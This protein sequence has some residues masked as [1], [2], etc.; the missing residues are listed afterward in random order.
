MDCP[1]RWERIGDC[2]QEALRELIFRESKKHDLRSVAPTWHDL[3]RHYF[4]EELAFRPAV[5]S[6]ARH[7]AKHGVAPQGLIPDSRYY[8]CFRI[9]CAL[10]FIGMIFPPQASVCPFS[11]L[12][13]SWSDNQVIEWLLVDLW[14]RRFD[15]WL[16]LSAIGHFGPFAFYGLE[17]ANPSVDA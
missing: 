8:L 1:P 12:P 14:V 2:L 5:D 16:K 7:L 11:E 13:Q 3:A 4:A 10:D 9:Q 6:A 17:P 15:H